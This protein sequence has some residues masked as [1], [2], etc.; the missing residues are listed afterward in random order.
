MEQG[1]RQ[2]EIAG[3]D[4]LKESDTSVTKKLAEEEAKGPFGFGIIKVSIY[5][6][7]RVHI[8]GATYIEILNG[9]LFGFT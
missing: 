1:F 4:S 6:S 3:K 7:R 2:A 5:F 9:K 8:P